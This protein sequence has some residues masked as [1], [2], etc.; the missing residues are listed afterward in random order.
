MGDI[1]IPRLY[2]ALSCSEMNVVDTTHV[3]ANGFYGQCE[4]N[5]ERTDNII[6]ILSRLL[7]KLHDDKLLDDDE[8]LFI[9]RGY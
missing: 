4:K 1:T 8:I 3:F 9:L 2:G 6:G 7:N 5:R